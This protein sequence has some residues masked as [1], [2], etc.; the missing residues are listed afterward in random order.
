[1]TIQ[2]TGQEIY[3]NF[4]KGPGPD[5]LNVSADIVRTVAEGYRD[6]AS[7]THVLA[8]ELESAWQGD[9][10]EAAQR[11]TRPV[12][13]EYE[14]AAG[15]LATAEDLVSRQAE[16]FVEARNRVV[17][18]PPAPTE[19]RPWVLDSPDTAR[20]FLREVTAH[21]TAAR[22]NVDVMVGYTG[23]S[24]H[25]TVHL[26]RSYGTLA[27]VDVQVGAGGSSVEGG[28]RDAGSPRGGGDTGGD[29]GG[30]AGGA[31]GATAE[32]GEAA[33]TARPGVD[34]GPVIPG[35]ADPGE[36]ESRPTEVAGWTGAADR[37]GATNGTSGTG[38]SRPVD[39]TSPIGGPGTVSGPVGR[40]GAA[41][42]P[43][44]AG[45]FRTPGAAVPGR[46]DEQRTAARTGQWGTSHRPAAGPL[47][48]VPTGGARREEDGQRRAPAYLAEHDPEELFGYDE[49][50]SPATIG[51]VDRP[52][53]A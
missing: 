49:I 45:G 18:V 22:N 6:L 5:G 40:P 51:L 17:P 10:A 7:R 21:L 16:S 9:A 24:D 44:G 47:G 12:I 15:E 1:M 14:F 23:A 41:G 11:A 38:G 42:R 37:S 25:N 27:T 26:P 46:G 53:E 29:T 39:G 50:V 13:A 43:G 30:A 20:T 35:A 48:G 32:G 33:G 28:P 34:P 3:E 36:E 2:Y 52:A 19:V 8:R 31:A 4:Q